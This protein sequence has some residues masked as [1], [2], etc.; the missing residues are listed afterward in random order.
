MLIRNDMNSSDSVEF[1][2]FFIDMV[3]ADSPIIIWADYIFR[4]MYTVECFN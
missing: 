1:H 4:I 2:I 3:D